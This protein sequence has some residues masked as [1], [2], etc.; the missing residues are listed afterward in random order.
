MLIYIPDGHVKEAK[1]EN[2]EVSKPS[3]G[4]DA[5]ALYSEIEKQGNTVRELKGKDPK[6]SA[7]QEAIAKLLE[8][9]KQYKVEIYVFEL[10]EF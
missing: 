10:L 2:K 3:A 8:L 6:S 1:V 7:A 9:K 5:S 4:V